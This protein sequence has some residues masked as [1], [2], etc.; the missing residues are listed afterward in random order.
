MEREKAILLS[1]SKKMQNYRFIFVVCS[2]VLIEKEGKFSLLKK[3]KTNFVVIVL[4][5]GQKALRE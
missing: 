4:R 3:K 2:L 1:K 5:L